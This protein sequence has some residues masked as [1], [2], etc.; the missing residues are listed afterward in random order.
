MAPPSLKST[1][2]GNRLSKEVTPTTNLPNAASSWPSAIACSL[3][4]P[5]VKARVGATSSRRR[6][7]N[8]SV[9]VM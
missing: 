7:T 2:L 9:H 3:T 6:C 5:R 4:F 1:P 8:A